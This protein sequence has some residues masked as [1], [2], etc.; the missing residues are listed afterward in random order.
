[1]KGPDA[2]QS[3]TYLQVTMAEFTAFLSV[4]GGGKP[5]VDQT[6]LTGKYDFDVPPLID[7]NAPETAEGGA[8]VPRPDAAHAFDWAAIG[9]ELKPI[10]LPAQNLIIDHIERPSAN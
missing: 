10:K 5:I 2:K 7:P 6:G 4:S 1:M 9:M 8:P 3:V